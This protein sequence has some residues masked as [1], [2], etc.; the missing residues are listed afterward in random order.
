MSFNSAN[1]N[2][3]KFTCSNKFCH[4]S[5]FVIKPLSPKTHI[6]M[7]HALLPC[8]KLPCSNFPCLLLQSLPVANHTLIC[9]GTDCCCCH[10]NEQT[11]FQGES[12]RRQ[13]SWVFFCFPPGCYAAVMHSP[14]GHCF[15]LHCGWPSPWRRNLDVTLSQLM[16]SCLKQRGIV[17]DK[18]ILW[19]P[20]EVKPPSWWT[21]DGGFAFITDMLDRRAALKW[22]QCLVS[23]FNTESNFNMSCLLNVDADSRY[24]FLSVV[25]LNHAGMNLLTTNIWNNFLCHSGGPSNS[26]WQ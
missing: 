8:L 13:S 5:Q 15:C 16:F 19:N 23:D 26:R 14:N 22:S 2:H 6:K 18:I 20:R 10:R 9:Q 4:F 17:D 11:L 3:D 7:C 25:Q 21:H 1:G 24:R 12:S